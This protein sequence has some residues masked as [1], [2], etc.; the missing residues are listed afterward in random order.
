MH[1][2]IRNVQMQSSNPSPYPPFIYLQGAYLG[3]VEKPQPFSHN[4]PSGLSSTKREVKTEKCQIKKLSAAVAVTFCLLA[5][6]SMKKQF[7]ASREFP[8]V[9]TGSHRGSGS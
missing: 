5:A 3:I 8:H 6:E 7:Q 4:L 2:S 9:Y 1:P